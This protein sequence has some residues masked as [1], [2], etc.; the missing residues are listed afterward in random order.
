M[1]FLDREIN[2]NIFHEIIDSYKQF[3][4]SGVG[5]R[6]EWIYHVRPM[7]GVQFEHVWHHPQFPKL[8]RIKEEE[9]DV[10]TNFTVR[11]PREFIRWFKCHNLYQMPAVS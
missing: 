10:G 6:G 1:I 9:F 8:P 3:A 2:S 7:P 11:Q 5:F 4:Q